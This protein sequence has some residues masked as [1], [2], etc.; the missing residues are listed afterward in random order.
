MM[1]DNDITLT[2]EGLVEREISKLVNKYD[3]HFLCL[4]RE[5]IWKSGLTFYKQCLGDKSKLKRNLSISFDGEDGL[6]AGPI[7]A[8]FFS[9]LLQEMDKRLFEGKSVRRI[10]RKS[11]GSNH[12]VI[13]GMIIGHSLL[14]GGPAYPMLAP[15]VYQYLCTASEDE[16]VQSMSM[17]PCSD[18]IPKDA[19]T[20]A[21]H[22][23]IAKVCTMII[24][25]CLN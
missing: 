19:S 12:H 13:A 14:Q 11:W 9:C 10:P 24:V 15:A 6:D 25:S 23:V 2:A 5:E 3:D 17:L 1:D 16:V 18:D 4:N 21:I 7:K 20:L 22:D 8:E